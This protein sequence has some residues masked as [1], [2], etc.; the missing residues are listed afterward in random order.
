MR[1]RITLGCQPRD[2]APRPP[3]PPPRF[4]PGAGGDTPAS[5]LRE[6]AAPR[7]SGRDL[8]AFAF[9]HPDNIRDA[10]RRRPDHP[11]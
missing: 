7:F 3:L 2:T 10:Q 8:S 11:E 1:L 5:A 6:D 9:L 4:P